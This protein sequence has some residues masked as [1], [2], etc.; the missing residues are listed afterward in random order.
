MKNIENKGKNY[1]YKRN[2][3]SKLKKIGRDAQ[4]MFLYKEFNGNLSKISEFTGISR[5]TIYKIVEKSK[6]TEE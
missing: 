4:V 1:N 3:K 6:N 5:S 2:L